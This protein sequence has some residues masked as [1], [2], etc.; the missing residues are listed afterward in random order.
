MEKI[1]I[2]LDLTLDEEMIQRIDEVAKWDE[3]NRKEMLL[4]L[5]EAGLFCHIR[6]GLE[7]YERL[8]DKYPTR[9]EAEAAYKKRRDGQ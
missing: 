3:S 6:D 8:M 1:K 7:A 5:I 2:E 4:S 9:A